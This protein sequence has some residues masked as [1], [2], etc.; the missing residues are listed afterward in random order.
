MCIRDRNRITSKHFDYVLCRKDDLSVVCAIELDDRSHAALE[1]KRRDV[2]LDK[3]CS[4]LLLPLVR[5]QARAA[6]SI[7]TVRTQVLGPLGVS[8][9]PHASVTLRQRAEPVMTR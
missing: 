9:M 8:P 6:Y 3:V 7:P 2:F 1:R 5:I 4:D